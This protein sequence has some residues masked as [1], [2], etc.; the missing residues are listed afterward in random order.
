MAVEELSEFIVALCKLHRQINHSSIQD[1]RE[2]L[3]DAQI[4]L[5]QMEFLY[6]SA[7]VDK[8]KRQKRLRLKAYL[9]QMKELGH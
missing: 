8:I 2:E 5:E 1:V 6:G 9:K 7:H 4:M 3:A